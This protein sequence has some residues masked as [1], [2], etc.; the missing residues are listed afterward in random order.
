MCCRAFPGSPILYGLTAPSVL[1][2]KETA[3]GVL[4]APRAY[5]VHNWY[6]LPLNELGLI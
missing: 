3:R 4:S 1:Q 6:D 5:Y 2:L